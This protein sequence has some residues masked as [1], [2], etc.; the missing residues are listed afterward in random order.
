MPLAA[1]K[2]A[3]DDHAVSFNAILKNICGLDG[4]YDDLAVVGAAF[5]RSAKM[6]VLR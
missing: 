3:Q 4:V 6:R 5:Q 2:H 1:M